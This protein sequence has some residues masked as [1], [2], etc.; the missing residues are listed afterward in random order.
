V[1]LDFSR[2]GKPTDNAF[3]ETFNGRF[4][5][6][7]LNQ[8]GFLT[9]ARM[10]PKSWSLGADTTTRNGHTARSATRSRSADETRGRHQFVTLS[11]A[12]KLCLRAVQ[13][14]GSDQEP[15][16]STFRRSKVG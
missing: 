12:G 1:I 2:S 3:I 10:R 5:A 7:C 16:N 9:L 11:E 13:R 6:E 15:E 4:R 14:W 8:H